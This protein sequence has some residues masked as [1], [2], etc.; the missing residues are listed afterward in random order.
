MVMSVIHRIHHRGI[1]QAGNTID[2]VEH[3]IITYYEEDQSYG[4][5]GQVQ[6]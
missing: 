1:E 3:I 6:L 2:N 5:E 4:I